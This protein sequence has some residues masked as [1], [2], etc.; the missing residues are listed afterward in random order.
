MNNYTPWF[1]VHYSCTTGL[2]A[3]L[4]ICYQ[5][6]PQV[7]GHSIHDDNRFQYIHDF[8]KQDLQAIALMGWQTTLIPVFT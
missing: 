5:N 1:C 2:I 3:K 6:R 7:M 4:V 8:H